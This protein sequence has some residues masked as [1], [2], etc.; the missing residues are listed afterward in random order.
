MKTV[1][2]IFA[3]AAALVS[4]AAVTFWLQTA[5]A[6][7]VI[8]PKTETKVLTG[9]Q[10]TA[11]VNA[12]K[13]DYPSL[14]ASAVHS[15]LCKVSRM[16]DAQG[17]PLPD[18]W[19]CELWAAG[20]SMSAADYSVCR[21]HGNCTNYDPGSWN[22]TTLTSKQRITTI[23]I[24]DPCLSQWDAWI[25]SVFT[26]ATM[27]LTTAIEAVRHVGAPTQIDCT[28]H[29]NVTQTA[30]QWINAGGGQPDGPE[31]IAVAE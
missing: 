3:C 15:L 6:G 7:D 17:N 18:V 22:G 5:N 4:A 20:V 28:R 12:A 27:G 11:V 29:G 13:C 23:T 10:K 25:A 14:N 21:A 9:P 30:V 2:W 16:K 31:P 1:Y 24:S 8:V 26:G 19:S